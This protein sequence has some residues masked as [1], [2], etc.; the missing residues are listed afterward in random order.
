M[1]LRVDGAIAVC[2]CLSRAAEA[3]RRTCQ[4]CR[5]VVSSDVRACVPLRPACS[6]SIVRRQRESL[7]ASL[8][9]GR[10]NRDG[11]WQ[12]VSQSKA[13]LRGWQRGRLYIVHVA[14]LCA[15]PP[16]SPKWGCVPASCLSVCLMCNRAF[17]SSH[18][19]LTAWIRFNLDYSACIQADRL[20][21]EER[22]SL[23]S[24]HNLS[25]QDPIRVQARPQ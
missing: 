14:C 5:L 9:R 23:S 3:S 17:T 25:R 16:R 19:N 24:L 20:T 4:G 18:G 13:G 10:V 8:L 12:S 11:R 2:A 7:D 1:R 6:P 15:H 22:S 21:E